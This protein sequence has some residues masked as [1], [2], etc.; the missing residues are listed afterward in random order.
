MLAS[1]EE[2]D[3]DHTFNTDQASV[4]MREGKDTPQKKESGLSDELVHD[5]YG[6]PIKYTMLLRR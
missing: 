3:E 6:R 2:L 5:W 4:E 1:A